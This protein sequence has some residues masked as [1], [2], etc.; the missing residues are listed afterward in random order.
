VRASRARI[1]E[2]ADRGR[3]EIERNLH[4]GAPSS[5]SYRSRSSSSCGWPPHRDLP[6]DARARV[7]EGLD[8]LRAGLAELRDLAHGLHP[9]VLTDHGL[10]AVL[11]LASRAAVPVELD[12]ELNGERPPLAIESV[13]Y[14]TVSEAL[15]NVASTPRR[16]TVGPSAPSRRRAA[17]RDRRRRGRRARRATRLGRPGPTRPHRRRRRH[18]ADLQPAQP[19]DRHA[20]KPSHRARGPLTAVR[21]RCCGCAAR[22]GQTCTTHGESAGRGAPHKCGARSCARRD[23]GGQARCHRPSP[24]RRA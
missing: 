3:R 2:A 6:E 9:A 23:E 1:L 19:R 17:R 24:T 18:L 15:T 4:D 21:A 22:T 14:F 7:A 11:T 12:I 20:G 5:G 10:K 13:A 16:P 8:E